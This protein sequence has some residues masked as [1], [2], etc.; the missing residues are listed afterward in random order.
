MLA[1]GAKNL[2]T[3]SN[4]GTT[5]RLVTMTPRLDRHHT[6]C[7]LFGG[8]LSQ[9]VEPVAPN[10]PQLDPQRRGQ[11]GQ[12][13]RIQVARL[14]QNVSASQRRMAAQCDLDRGREPAQAEAVILPDQER[15]LR[16]VHLARDIAH[17]PLR[18]GLCQQTDRSGVA[19]KHPVGEHVD[20][21]QDLPHAT[22]L[23]TT[24]DEP[25]TTGRSVAIRR[26]GLL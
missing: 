14:L 17:P 24:K 12:C 1:A 3:K 11:F 8:D 16:Q 6:M 21:R 23:A 26:S 10:P 25:V 15:S 5:D 4:P 9:I 18:T 13:V 22:L 7:N 2:E 20:L 19:A